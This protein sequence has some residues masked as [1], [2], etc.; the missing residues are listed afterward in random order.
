MGFKIYLETKYTRVYIYIR[1]YK[2][3]K[4]DLHFEARKLFALMAEEV[5]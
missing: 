1:N 3:R 4:Y 2:L 5:K